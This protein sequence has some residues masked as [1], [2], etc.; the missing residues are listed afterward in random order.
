MCRSWSA[1]FWKAS[2]SGST[3]F[4]KWDI[5][6]FSVVRVKVSHRPQIVRT[7]KAV[8]WQTKYVLCFTTYMYW[9]VTG[10]NIYTYKW[11]WKLCRSW[12]ACLWKSS[13]SGSTLFSKWDIIM[14]SVL[15][16]QVSHRLQIVKTRKAAFWQTKDVF[17]FYNIYVLRGH[18]L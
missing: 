7:R 14:L 4:S 3:L 2:W 16:V 10:Y 9:G 6:M 17:V 13:W 1:G 12:S 8:L 11:S 15:R 18:R 5:F